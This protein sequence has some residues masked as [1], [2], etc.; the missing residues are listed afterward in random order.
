MC[1]VSVII[2]VYNGETYLAQCLDS[3]IGQTLKEIEII[4]VNDGSKDRTQQILEKYAEK[5]SRIQIIS[6]ENGGAGA[7]RNAG[8]RIARGEYLSILDG[9]DFFEPDMLEKAYKKA[10]ESRAELLVFGSDQYYETTG[11]YK[12]V[13]WTIRR[14]ALPPYRPMNYRQFTDNVF[15]V[16][17]GWTW[18]KLFLRSF[19]EEQRLYFQ[20]Q[21]TSN[22]L[23]FT[24]LA[25]V[26]A[27]NIEILDEVLIHQRR[28][29]QNSLSNTREQSW[30]CFY[31][32]LLELREE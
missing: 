30:T 6:Q 23:L 2:P 7:A 18:D 11:E 19:V 22:D 25:I 32:A 1:K 27:K 9:D 5:D 20:E 16:F 12:S 26:T 29:N 15:K 3:I 10:K 14:H 13:A 28:D 31:E 24:F 17:V 4:C 21:R 8:L